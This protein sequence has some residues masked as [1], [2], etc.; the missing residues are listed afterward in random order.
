MLGQVGAKIGLKALGTAGSTLAGAAGAVAKTGQAFGMAGKALG[1]AAQGVKQTQSPSNV[2]VGNFGMAASAGRQ[3]VT[4]GGA[5]PAPKSIAKPQVSTKMPTE[6]LLDTAVKYLV[7]IDKSL[8]SQLE[9][10][11][12]SYQEQAQLDREA[13]I[14]SRPSTTFNDIKD[15]SLIHI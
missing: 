5:L 6:A 9:L 11:R 7:S 3:K 15:L 13:I 12:R 10:D 4:G 2:V 8:K 1:D 14:E